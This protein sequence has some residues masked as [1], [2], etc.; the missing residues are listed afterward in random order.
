V[1]GLL[2]AAELVPAWTALANGRPEEALR[3]IGP[4][5]ATRP[6]R[7]AWAAAELGRQPVT[8]D[9]V[10]AAEQVVTAL[11]QGDDEI[12]AQ[13]EYLRARL[14]QLHY[15]TPDPARATE[16]FLALADRRP[17]SHWAQLGLVKL[18]MMRIYAPPGPPSAD[19]LAPAEALLARIHEPQLQRDLHLQIG[20]AGVALGL[21]TRR[22]LPHFV[23]ADRLGGLTGAAL[24]DLIV[25][26]GTLSFRAGEYPQAREYFER[27]L[28]EYPTNIRAYAVTRLL[29][30]TRRG[31]AGEAAP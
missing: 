20:Q 24:E 22:F 28:R 2:T 27:Y 12:G 30:R 6:E 1:P 23:A 5:P 7:L 10:R 19:R 25:Q 11:A 8:D 15:A 21:P 14:Y 16:L 26:I 3:R 13:A 9:H 17:Q 18:A 29:E 31:L 4:E